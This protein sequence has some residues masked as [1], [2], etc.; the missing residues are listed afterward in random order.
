MLLAIVTP[1][2]A[3]F[4]YIKPMPVFEQS[5]QKLTDNERNAKKQAGKIHTLIGRIVRPNKEERVFLHF[6]SIM[7]KNERE[8]KLKVYPSLEFAYLIPF[9][10]YVF[11]ASIRFYLHKKTK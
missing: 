10:F 3:V 11:N 1:F 4:L 8:F 9:F 7:L 5:L 6:S 2:L